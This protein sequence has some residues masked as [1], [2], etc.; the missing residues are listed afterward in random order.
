[1]SRRLT[2]GYALA[3]TVTLVV[4]LGTGRWL[5]ERTLLGNVNLLQDA[6]NVEV[7]QDLGTPMGTMPEAELVQKNEGARRR[8]RGP[9]FFPDSRSGRARDLPFPQPGRVG[10]ARPVLQRPAL[11][12]R[13]AAHGRV[14]TSEYVHGP[15]HLQ[16][17]TRLAPTEQLLR[18]YAQ[19][20]PH[21]RRRGGGGESRPR[22][23]HQLAGPAAGARHPGDGAAH[24]RGQPG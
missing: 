3:V 18:Q 20:S 15:R 17:G 24:R 1:M 19:V 16:I 12:D 14:Y 23:R 21:P 8:R 2:V 9:V 11:D 6:E 5:L 13:P 22:L 4:A 7:M 10:V